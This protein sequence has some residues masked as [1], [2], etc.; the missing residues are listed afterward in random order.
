MKRGLI[1]FLLFAACQNNDKIKSFAVE[2][3]EFVDKIFISKKN[4][5]YVILEKRNENWFLQDSSKVSKVAINLLLKETISEIKVKGPAAKPARNN[6]LKTMSITGKKVELYSKNKNIKTYYV[7]GTTPD[8]LGTYMLMDGAKTPY[9]THVPGFNGYLNI[10]YSVDKSQ[11]QSKELF[12]ISA[13]QIEKVNLSYPQNPEYS[14]ELLN[15]YSNTIITRSG[16]KTIKSQMKRSYFRSFTRKYAEG[17][18]IISK[19]KRDTI[20]GA[21]PFA[22]LEIWSKN[23]EKTGLDIFYR[24]SYD[25]MHGLYTQDGK[26]LTKDPSR[27]NARL[28]NEDKVFVIQQFVFK[29]ILKRAVDF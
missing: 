5:N 10:R 16:M 29:D 27:Y 14:F 24:D 28:N 26:R 21:S 13:N 2:N 9:V 12:D 22:I 18:D 1:I 23:G 17:F 20:F 25:K 7:G 11:W 8:M 15:N 19:S 4:G 3:P 6:V